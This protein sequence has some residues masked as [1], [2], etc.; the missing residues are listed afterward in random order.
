MQ[1]KGAFVWVG[2]SP[3][4]VNCYVQLDETM[5]PS[6]ARVQISLN[7]QQ[8]EVTQSAQTQRR[9]SKVNQQIGHLKQP[10]REHYE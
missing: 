6:G 7:T 2:E 5:P 3:D 8:V 9:V 10:A 1:L 4:F